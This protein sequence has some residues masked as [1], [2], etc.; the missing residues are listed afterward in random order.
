MVLPE[1]TPL[2]AWRGFFVSRSDLVP[3][4]SDDV[5]QAG[6]GVA[7]LASVLRTI[8]DHTLFQPDET[9]VVAVSGGVDSMVLLDLLMRLPELRLRLVVAHLNHCLRGEESDADETLVRA[10]AARFGLP[11]ASRRVDVARLKRE[12]GLSLEE[13]GRVARY[14]FLA[15]TAGARQARVVA[16]AHHADDQAETVLMRLLRGAA[17]SGLCAMAPKSADG[18]YVR[19]LLF[20]PRQEIERYAR[21][22]GIP[23]RHDAS[24]DDP[25]FLRNRIRHE[26]IPAL[27][28][29][30]TAIRERLAATAAAL[31]E[32][33]AVLE[34]V[35]ARALA[36]HGTQAENSVTLDLNG[37]RGELRGLRLRLYRYAIRKAKG[38]LARISGRH[39]EEIDRLVFG[40][41]PQAALHL[42]AGL[43]VTRVYDRLSFQAITEEDEFQP[44]EF[45]VA[46]KGSYSLPGGGRLVVS[47]AR[48]PFAAP[49]PSPLT[50]RID[51]EK[52]PFPWLVRTFRPGDR[53]VPPGMTGR[54]K[55][56][57]LFMEERIP[58]EV[59]RRIP[60]VFSGDRLVWVGGVR[61]GAAAC[62]DASTRVCVNAEI[63]DVNPLTA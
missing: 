35:T 8:T 48:A 22:Q 32:D 40:E 57:K 15:E 30:N 9:V 34:E 45:L 4:R 44:Y 42:P 41:R 51:L 23:F 14:A 39:L 20:T 58:L 63:L 56:K 47:E 61:T 53:F 21:E 43:L 33:E 17:A 36:V 37:V 55:V 24:N 62:T 16:L 60:L 2:S 38:D 28:T 54:K 49:S 31:A 46:G 12:E 50:V 3:G 11:F 59:R 18:R 6:R 13:A 19:P 29:Y 26:L 52:A 5:G 27:A 10:A 7:M 1:E 25:Q